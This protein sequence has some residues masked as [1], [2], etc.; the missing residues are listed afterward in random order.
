MWVLFDWA[1]SDPLKPSRLIPLGIYT[2]EARASAH[3]ADNNLLIQSHEVVGEEKDNPPSLVYLAQNERGDLIIGLYADMA[4]AL[5][6]TAG[7]ERR[8]KPFRVDARPI[9]LHR[10]HRPYDTICSNL[11]P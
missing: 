2:T 5:K 7:N 6:A 8:V 11:L 10:L 1:G 9:T 4:D 3:K